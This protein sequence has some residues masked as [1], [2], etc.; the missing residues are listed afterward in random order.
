MMHRPTPS[1]RARVLAQACAVAMRLRTG[2]AGWPEIEALAA[3][4][5]VLDPGD[6]ARAAVMRCRS[7]LQAGWRDPACRAEAGA[8]LRRDALRAMMPAPADRARVD[9]HG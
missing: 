5:A 3:G 1:P 2:D 9:I 8:A 6:A 7:A 4:A